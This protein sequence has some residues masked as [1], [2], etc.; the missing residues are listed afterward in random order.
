MTLNAFSA[1]TARPFRLTLLTLACIAS[2]NSHATQGRSVGSGDLLIAPTRVMLEDSK[3]SIDVNLLNI[4]SKRAT[5]RIS[6]I[7]QR[8]N[9]D[10]KLEEIQT[11]GPGERFADELVQFS[12]HQV[13][14]EPNV[15]QL[16]RIQLRLPAELEAGEYRS[17]ILIRAIPEPVGTD[18]VVNTAS[19]ETGISMQLAPIYGVSIPLIVRHGKTSSAI[20]MKDLKLATTV[21]GEQVVTGHLT[22]T[23]NA[24]VYGEIQLMYIKSGMVSTPIGNLGGVAVYSPNTDRNFSIRLALPTSVNLHGGTIKVMY[25]RSAAESN[26]PIAIGTLDVS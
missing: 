1:F 25:I 8:M 2:A 7:H 24:S 13:V 23:G 9:D 5:Y 15:S 20:G 26:K 14:L 17:H 12:P 3:R 21:S 22:R 19:G 11:A 10:G 4:G 18:T 6:L 16:V